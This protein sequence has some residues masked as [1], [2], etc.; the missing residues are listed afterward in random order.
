MTLVQRAFQPQQ[1]MLGA[2]I[3]RP[4]RRSNDGQR[5]LTAIRT[6]PDLRTDLV[7]FVGAAGLEPATPRL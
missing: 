3:P 2:E 5:I 6:D 1:G 7:F 4:P